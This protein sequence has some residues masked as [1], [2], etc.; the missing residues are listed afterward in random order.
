M[1]NIIIYA[2]ITLVGV[3]LSRGVFAS[4]YSLTYVR[5]LEGG[6][7]KN[8]STTGHPTKRSAKKKMMSEID[9]LTHKGGENCYYTSLTGQDNWKQLTIQKDIHCFEINKL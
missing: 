1:E 3:I 5:M 4:Q 6:T 8:I 7:L 2:V 9:R